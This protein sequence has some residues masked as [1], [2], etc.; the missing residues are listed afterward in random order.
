VLL[1]LPVDSLGG[2]I[3]LIMKIERIELREIRMPLVAPFE[4]SFERTTERRILLV[5]V[6]SEGI[7]GWG[8]CVAG[9]DPFYLPESTDT[10]W[11]LICDYV[12]PMTIGRDI[13]TPEQAF[14]LTSRI[15]GH[16]MAR[17]A[18][19]TA[20]W[21][22]AAR[23]EQRPLW[24]LLG[25]TQTEISSGVSI[26]IQETHSELLRKIEK[27][28]A[29]GYRRIKIKIKPG[30]DI[31]AVKAVRTEYPEI[32]L[33]VDANSAYTLEDAGMLRGLDEFDLKYAEQ[34]L[35]YDDII[36]HAQLQRMMKTPLCLDESINSSED[37]RKA[38]SIEACKV[39][40]IKLGRVGGHT[41]A[42]KIQSIC[43]EQK[44]PV[45]CGGMLEAGIG[46]AHNIAMSTL[47]GFVYPG[48]VSA[49][50]RY[51]TEDIITPPV[52]VSSHGT[53]T[54]PFGP[55]IGFEVNEERIRALT[56]RNT[57]IE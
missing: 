4:T 43:R 38:L 13:E 23:R 19:E 26:G 18:V 3:L 49:S 16:R 37:A 40:N 42:R 33:T 51:W 1:F 20:I 32:V 31:D 39:I 48:D 12:G 57:T 11:T 15:R 46:R 36:D 25:G 17:A 52:D 47:P 21:D 53:I 50:A 30:W 8:E 28:L 10:A 6:F 56:V 22:L 54:A 45:W 7:E 44:I 55:G 27:E 29:A 35:A 2:G 14:S 41:E 9:E 24:Q 34:P 5:K